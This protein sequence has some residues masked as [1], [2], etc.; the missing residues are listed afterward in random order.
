MLPIELISKFQD[1]IVAA[2]GVRLRDSIIII[3]VVQTVLVQYDAI[4]DQSV[5]RRVMHQKMRNVEYR[6]HQHARLLV[7][8]YQVPGSLPYLLGT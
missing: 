7:R 4:G 2:F 5:T 1:S 8:Y 3:D 6:Y